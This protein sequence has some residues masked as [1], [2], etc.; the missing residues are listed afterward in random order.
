MT[1]NGNTSSPRWN[2]HLTLLAGKI[3][4][5]SLNVN[6]SLTDATNTQPA[7]RPPKMVTR[8]CAANTLGKYKRRH[9][10]GC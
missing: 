3:R 5:P 9:N 4:I 10:N 1:T 7:E 6:V 8:E 2:G